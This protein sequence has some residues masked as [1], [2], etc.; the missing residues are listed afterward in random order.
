[1]ADTKISADPA[2][3]ALT[4][5]ELFAGVQ[6]SANVKITADQIL[7]FA[8]ASMRPPWI[9]GNWYNPYDGPLANGIALVQ[10]SMRFTPFFIERTITISD[11]G[12][13]I[14]TISGGGSIQLAVYGSA[15]ATSWPTGNALAV[16]GNISTA[17]AVGVSGD[18]TGSNVTL[19]PGLYWGAVNSDNSVAVCYALAGAN[20][21][22][23]RLVGSANLGTV[24]GASTT[25]TFMLTLASTFNTWPD[26]TGG[27]FAESIA[28]SHALVLLKAA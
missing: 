20:L 13:R 2:A 9:A 5:A 25:G 28:L 21:T 27:G 22:A 7:T 6:S 17:S 10:N 11:L 12:T 16:T 19:T 24:T 18:I 23:A 26:V 8:R 3:S 14:N 1:M 4:G 15:A